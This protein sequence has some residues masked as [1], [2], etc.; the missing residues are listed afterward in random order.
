M[1]VHDTPGVYYERADA[2]TPSIAAV[3]TDIA[4]FV[5]LAERGPVDE[6]LPVESFR[7]FQA[8]YGGFQGFA[9]LAYAVRGFFE[10]GGRRCWVVRVAASEA[11][12]GHAPA[13]TVFPSAAGVPMWRVAASSSGVWGNNLSVRFSE[14]SAA[15]TTS[16]P[17]ESDGRFATVTTVSGFRR[18][19]LVRIS[20]PGSATQWKVVSDVDG[21]ESRL[22][23]VHPDPMAQLVYDAPLE[24]F[25]PDRP[26]VI[27]SVEYT[28]AVRLRGVPVLIRE[29]LSTIPEHPMYG[30]RILR[31]NVNPAD[32]EARRTLPPV[33]DP[34]VLKELRED[35]ATPATLA[36]STG[37]VRLEGGADGL[38]ALTAYD[39]IGETPSPSDSD[40]VRRLRQRGLERLSQID[41]VAILAIPDILIRPI[42]PTVFAP[43]PPCVPDPCLPVDAEA[44]E[45]WKDAV[46]FE[47][48]PVFSDSDIFRVQSAMISQC[49]TLRDRFAILEAPYS[50][51]RDDASGPA[52]IR[53]WRS[54][55]DSKFAALYYP[56]LLVSDEARSAQSPMRE[57]PPGGHIAGQY[58][59]GDIAV[60]VHKAP[61][62]EPLR[63]VQATT[64]ATDAARH[65]LLNSLGI[66]AITVNSG[67]GIRIMG[68]RTVSSDSDWRYVNVRRLVSMVGKAIYLATQWAVFEPNDWPARARIRLALSSFLIALWRRGALTGATAAEAFFVQCD[69]SNNPPQ[70]RENG[71]LVADVGIAPSVPFEFIVLRVGRQGNEFE[72][73][74]MQSMGGGQW[75]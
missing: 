54:R 35:L 65:G 36:P 44:P 53:S 75:R 74:E 16:V 48:P 51:S 6:A 5:G 32:L 45:P 30:P 60:G 39:F 43:P 49:E 10:N 63:W 1:I 20:Q 62:N 33:P 46:S 12:R 70:Q 11:G 42:P 27:E 71:W 26:L 58:A 19:T 52:L 17:R 25:D 55:F 8:H 59:A 72:I 29:R 67:R 37:F 14:T 13:G 34:V 47:M 23:W 15:Q 18:G 73:E 68:A 38:D 64:A 40:I 69:E 4:G 61:A 9:Y 41:E 24:G 28:L 2:R 3:R 22:Q 57:V 66:N 50:A 7:Q 21:A 31:P 56:W